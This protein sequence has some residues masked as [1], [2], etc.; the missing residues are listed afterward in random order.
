MHLVGVR[1]RLDSGL[2][3]HLHNSG[4]MIY[5]KSMELI[6][7]PVNGQL[8]D[9]LI[10]LLNS[11]DYHTL[12]LIVAFAKSSGVL[13]M[14]TAFEEFRSK[15]GKVNAF[16][17]V[18]LGGTSYEALTALLRCT[19]SLQIVHSE[20]GQTFH[21]KLYFFS[22]KTQGLLAI[23]SHNLT[24]GGLWTNFES[25]VLI[26]FINGDKVGSALIQE[27]SKFSSKMKSLGKSFMPL[28]CQAD[29]DNLLDRGYIFKEV[30]ERLQRAQRTGERVG[31]TRLFGAGLSAKLPR[32]DKPMGKKGFV[33]KA[34]LQK[35][36]ATSI[37]ESEKTI[38]FETRSMTGGSRNILDLSM[39]S[40]VLKGAIKGTAFDIG[41]TKFM[42][43]AVA[44]FG[45]DPSEKEQV[46]DVTINFDGVDYKGNSVL[47]PDGK[48]ANGTW[49]LQIKG[50][51]KD[52]S[53]ITEAFRAKEGV[54]YLVRKII[55]FTKVTDDY[56]SLSVFPET[57]LDRFKTA[58]DILGKN[59]ITE[60]AKFL[61][62]L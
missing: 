55:T 52:G 57:E 4:R 49:R 53:R 17:G 19:D 32:L 58:S 35:A 21:P 30:F 27:I 10:D 42:R 61:G 34:P 29:I 24:G 33:E 23:G 14:K 7:Q 39:K 43:G 1:V 51:S 44:F 15:G 2:R 16:V 6:N 48:K 12:D 26:P 8:G 40:L 25:S 56:F 37:I 62:V 41:E 20:N 13:R 47:F 60:N 9:R 36:H 54:N 50:V 18:D 46:R 3:P 11:S 28:K 38:W 5:G 45:L 59:G 31:R 22:G